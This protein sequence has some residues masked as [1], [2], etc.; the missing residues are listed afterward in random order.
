[1]SKKPVVAIICFEDP[2]SAVGRFAATAARLLA[3]HGN[4]VQ[5]FT[6]HALGVDATG[7][8]EHVLNTAAGASLIDDVRDFSVATSAALSATVPAQDEEMALLAC[9]WTAIPAAQIASAMRPARVLLCLQT[10]ER[11][12]ADMTSE[13]S[14]QIEALEIQGIQQAAAVLARGEPTVEMARKLALCES[15]D[16]AKVCALVESFAIA[17]FQKPLDAGA[18]KSK[19][20]IGPIDPTVLFVGTLDEDRG[21]DLI[22]KAVPGI[23][24]KHKQARF[25]FV[26]DGP[27]FWMLRIYSRYL[28]LDHAVRVVGHLAGDA[29]RELVQA[30]DIV[31]V[32]QRKTCE[33]WPILAAWSAG[34]AVVASHEAG[35]GLVEHEHN[36]VL[37]YPLHE[38]VAWGVNRIM[39]DP[40]LW[41]KIVENGKAKVAT[42]FGEGLLGGQLAKVINER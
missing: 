33:N 31:V 6:R 10:L 41:G 26:G 2:G 36:G 25:I 17:D 29:V 4:P 40:A 13:Q 11:Q 28:N 38:S 1:M 12:R 22:V 16:P 24:K 37:I 34:K 42:Q 9:E 23:L 20:L 7:V 32:P 19:Y 30:A 5:L 14:R 27:L 35:I 39:E 21:S 3:G 15:G 18:V 8:T